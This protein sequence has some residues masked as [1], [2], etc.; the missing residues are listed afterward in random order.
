MI[1]S[2]VLPFTVAV[3]LYPSISLILSPPTHCITRSPSPLQQV[4]ALPLHSPTLLYPL[5]HLTGGFWPYPYECNCFVFMSSETA[6]C[7]TCV[8]RTLCA[9]LFFVVIFLHLKISSLLL[10]DFYSVFVK[11]PFC[12]GCIVPYF[13][14]L[15]NIYIY[16]YI[17]IYTQGV[18]RFVDSTA[19]GDFLGLCDKKCLYKRMC[20]FGRLRSYGHFLIPVHAVV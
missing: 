7:D 9:I 10:A 14:L 19:G 16:I 3:A 4:A 11:M 2:D 17:Y 5:E 15:C 8:V 13:L 1:I 18:S 6:N 12:R 20:D